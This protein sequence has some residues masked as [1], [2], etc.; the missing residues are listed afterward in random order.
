MTLCEETAGPREI[1]F[2]ADAGD[3]Y[4]AVPMGQS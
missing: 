1:G 3:R 2:A 4:T